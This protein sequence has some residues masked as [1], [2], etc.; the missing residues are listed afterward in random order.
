MN[1][2]PNQGMFPAGFGT[3]NPMNL[4]NQHPNMMPMNI[5]DN[6]MPLD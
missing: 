2:I 4:L 6:Y 3:V 5:L 1:L